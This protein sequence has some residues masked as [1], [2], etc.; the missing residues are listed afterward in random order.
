VGPRTARVNE[1]ICGGDVLNLV[2]GFAQVSESG[3]GNQEKRN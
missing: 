1:L 2:I 3:S